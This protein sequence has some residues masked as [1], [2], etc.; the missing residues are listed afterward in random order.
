MAYKAFGQII[1]LRIQNKNE[2]INQLYTRMFE[3]QSILINTGIDK[4]FFKSDESRYEYK[5]TKEKRKK[6]E[7]NI[8]TIVIAC[9]ITVCKT[10]CAV[11]KRLMWLD[12]K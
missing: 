10:L 8:K 7:E 2:A 4:D 1:E 12:G 9:C 5:I 3:I 11:R 6:N